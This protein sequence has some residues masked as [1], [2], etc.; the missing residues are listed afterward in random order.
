M[1]KIPAAISF[2]I[3]IIDAWGNQEYVDFPANQTTFGLVRDGNWGQAAIPISDIRGEFID[4]RMMSYEFVILE[5]N[6]AACEFALDDM[7]ICID[8]ALAV[9]CCLPSGECAML[10]PVACEFASGT[11]RP[12]SACTE[13]T[14]SATP[15]QSAS[16]GKLKNIYRD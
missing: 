7:V 4:L 10:S 9:P 15:V 16:W 6:G 2:K 12:G 11:Q 14:C 3:G 13:T 5:V 8:P 1:I